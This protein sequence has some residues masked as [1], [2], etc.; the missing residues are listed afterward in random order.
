MSLQPLIASVSDGGLDPAAFVTFRSAAN[1]AN[2]PTSFVT[3]AGGRT[4]AKPPEPYSIRAETLDC[5]GPL[6][7]NRIRLT[8]LLG[9]SALFVVPLSYRMKFVGKEN[10]QAKPLLRVSTIQSTALFVVQFPEIFVACSTLKF[11]FVG[12]TRIFCPP[13]KST[14]K[15]V[16]LPAFVPCR[17]RIAPGVAPVTAKR[18][19]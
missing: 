15:F 9:S 19:D 10:M 1:H 4:G 11:G 17:K 14:M 5:P 18:A 16:P 3:A 2:K 12:K 7:S 13:S 8:V 6:F